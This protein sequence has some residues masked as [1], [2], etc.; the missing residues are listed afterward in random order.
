MNENSRQTVEERLSHIN[1]E[2][3]NVMELMQNSAAI[4]RQIIAIISELE[5]EIEDIYVGI[6]EDDTD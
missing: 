2:L 1:A 3:A 5:N 6:G 4:T